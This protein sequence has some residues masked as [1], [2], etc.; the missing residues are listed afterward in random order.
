M[1]SAKPVL[2]SDVGALSEIVDPGRTG[3]LVPADDPEALADALVDLLGDRHRLIGWGQQARHEVT[4]VHAIDRQ[5][6]R[7]EALYH[8]VLNREPGPSVT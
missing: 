4:R 5:A 2:A 6:G 3:S 8:S 7:V 1:A